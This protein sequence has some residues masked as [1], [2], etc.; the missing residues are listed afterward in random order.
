MVLGDLTFMYAVFAVSDLIDTDNNVAVWR[1]FFGLIA[2]C[3]LELVAVRC[4][5][6]FWREGGPYTWPAVATTLPPQRT[7]I[8]QEGSGLL[9]SQDSS[10]GLHEARQPF[11]CQRLSLKHNY[12]IIKCLLLKSISYW[13]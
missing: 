2:C 9:K 4:S 13:N 11:T 3:H 10:G 5:G 12:I 8:S 7:A 6:G 1:F